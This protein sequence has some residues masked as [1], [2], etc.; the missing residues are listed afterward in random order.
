MSRRVSPPLP[1]ALL[2]AF[3]LALPLA[4]CAGTSSTGPITPDWAGFAP[5]GGPEVPADRSPLGLE[6]DTTTLVDPA[7]RDALLADL[8]AAYAA[9][10]ADPDNEDGLIWLGRRLAYLGRYRDAVAVYTEGLA[11]HPDSVK[12]LRHRGHRSITLLRFDDAVA[13]LSR[14]AQLIEGTPDEVE[15]DGAPNASGL[16]RSTLH[17]NIDYHLGLAHFLRGEWAAARAAYERGYEASRVNDDMLVATSW[18]LYLT[19][20]ISGERELADAVLLP[21]RGNMDVLENHAYHDLLLMARGERTAEQVLEGVEP[22]SLE[23]ATRGYGLS[24]LLR[25]QGRRFEEAAELLLTIV[26]SDAWPSFGAIA[27]EVELGR[28]PTDAP[29]V[30]P[31]APADMSARIAQYWFEMVF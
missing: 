24:W 18:C 15:P 14:A 1:P 3:G 30:G 22:G 5:A 29:A 26:E 4:G 10:A 8:Y 17:S 23:Y 2:L 31:D 28:I 9:H 20:G 13:D 27:A 12:L 19:L 6:H 25:W 21:I 16:P 7:R 11:R